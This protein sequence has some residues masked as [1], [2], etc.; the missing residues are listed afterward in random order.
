[1][2]EW[3]GKWKGEGEKEGVGRNDLSREYV[4]LR[5]QRHGGAGSLY[6]NDE[7]DSSKKY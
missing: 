3:K 5:A 1:M 7:V 4:R 2:K 6:S